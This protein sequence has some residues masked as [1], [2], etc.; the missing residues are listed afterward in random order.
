MNIIVPM[1]CRNHG[2]FLETLFY[3]AA[4]NMFDII[5]HF[6]TKLK[7]QDSVI[8]PIYAKLVQ[9]VIHC[10][11]ITSYINQK[12]NFLPSTLLVLKRLA[13]DIYF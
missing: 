5:G 2:L 3:S 9:I 7:Y 1:L 11:C 6:Y 8:Y 13:G 12:Y 10:E 4:V